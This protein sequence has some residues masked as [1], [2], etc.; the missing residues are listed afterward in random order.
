[1]RNAG[2]EVPAAPPPESVTAEDYARAMLNMLEDM[3]AEKAQLEQTQRAIFNILGDSTEEKRQLEDTQSAMVNL[4]E[5]FDVERSKTEAA[6]RDLH[7]AVESLRRAKEAADSVNRELEGFSYSVSHDLRAPLR[8]IDSF[9]ALLRRSTEGKLDGKSQ[10]YMDVVGGAARQMS[11]LIEDLLLFSR[12][13]KVE[14]TS[15]RVPLDPLV[16][17]TLRMLQPEIQGRDVAWTLP[18]LPEVRGDAALLQTVL[19][20]LVANALKFTRGRAP[21]LIEIGSVPAPDEVVVYVKDNGAGFDMRHADKLF[22]LFQRLHGA[23]EFEGTGVGL[24][25]VRRIVSRHGGRTWATGAVDQGAT[26]YFSVPL[27]RKD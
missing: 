12:M 6:N 21:A 8:H 15:G 27:H 4:L 20:N 5:D 23:S 7:H 9:L 22:T 16:R 2:S 25:N 26:F 14:M 19:T 11:R 10:H 17:S 3:A 18:P 24:A 1:M 13:G